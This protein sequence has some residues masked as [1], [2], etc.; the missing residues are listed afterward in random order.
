MNG[1]EEIRTP[2]ISVLGHIDHGKTSLLDS[3]RGSAVTAKEAGHVT[4]HI[5]ATEIPI[6][7][8]KEICEPLKRDWSGIEVPGL[9]FIDTPGHHAF[10]SL[11]KRGSALAEHFTIIKDA[12]RRCIEQNRQDKGME[13][14]EETAHN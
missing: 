6:E 10:A 13:F 14:N 7:T 8:I 5:G 2:I 11:R 12:F 4:Q 1:K 3:I 9:L